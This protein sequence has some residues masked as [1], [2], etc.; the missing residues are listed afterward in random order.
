MFLASKNCTWLLRRFEEHGQQDRSGETALIKA[1]RYG[2]IEATKYLANYE[3][4]IPD[5]KDQLPIHYSLKMQNYTIFSCLLDIMEQRVLVKYIQSIVKTAAKACFNFDILLKLV[6]KTFCYADEFG[7][8]WH[9]YALVN[10]NS[11]LLKVIQ[12]ITGS[13]P[14]DK[15]CVFGVPIEPER[16]FRQL[17][18]LRS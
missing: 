13:K 16:F 11:V 1:V 14:L 4:F 3:W 10:Q 18:I 17:R 12:T 6:S 7:R 9:F 2:A 8:G 5:N 15:T